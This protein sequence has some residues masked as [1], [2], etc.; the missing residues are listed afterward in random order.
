MTADTESHPFNPFSR[1]TV[2]TRVIIC[3]AQSLRP[4]IISKSSRLVL[5]VFRS[6]AMLR[7]DSFICNVLFSRSSIC[8]RMLEFLASSS[9]VRVV[10][11]SFFRESRTLRSEML[12]AKLVVGKSRS[13]LS[14]G[15]P[16][17]RLYAVRMLVLARI[18]LGGS[19]ES[20]RVDICCATSSASFA[21][22]T[23]PETVFGKSS[24]P[25][26]SS[27]SIPPGTYAEPMCCLIVS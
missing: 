16:V 10:P 15:I 18:W 27:E 4:S 5:R 3:C 23:L 7:C 6:G 21:F 26:S 12:S 2:P 19:S 1:K 8:E 25:S 20:F 22:C 13:R 9:I 17:A 11:S 14:M 24:T